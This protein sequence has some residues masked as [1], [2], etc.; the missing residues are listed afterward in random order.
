MGILEFFTEASQFNP[1]DEFGPDSIYLCSPIQDSFGYTFFF[2]TK[3]TNY[4]NLLSGNDLTKKLENVH[5]Q[6]N[7]DC[8]YTTECTTKC[9]QNKCSHYL[10]KPQ[11][12]DFC[13]FV[14]LFLIDLN[15]VLKKLEPILDKCLKLETNFIQDKSIL[16]SKNQLLSNFEEYDKFLQLENY[17]NKSVDYS[18]TIENLRSSL[19]NMI[20]FVD[21]P[22]KKTNKK[23]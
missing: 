1:N 3:L 8:F 6:T 5:C 2:E 19:W 9:I 21:D 14:K 18:T 11:L 13:S 15:D 12:V 23:T 4:E 22:K 20:R 7:S 16:F 10:T 17:W